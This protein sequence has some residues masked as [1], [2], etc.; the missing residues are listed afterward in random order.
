MFRAVLWLMVA[1]LGVGSVASAEPLSAT[2]L[3]GRPAFG[4]PSMSPDGSRLAMVADTGHGQNSLIVMQINGTD[5]KPLLKTAVPGL[6]AV[7]NY[8]W[9]SNDVL[10]MWIDIGGADGSV[11]AMLDISKNLLVAQE[12][13][14]AQLVRDRWGDA[15]HVLIRELCSI[16]QFCFFVWNI[17]TNRGVAYATAISNQKGVITHIINKDQLVADTVG[18][19]GK[20]QRQSW[21]TKTSS[22]VAGTVADTAPVKGA[23]QLEDVEQTDSNAAEFVNA[24]TRFQALR[25]HANATAVRTS[26]SHDIVGAA[27]PLP[28]PAFLSFMP[29]LDAAAE[30]AAAALPDRRVSWL[31]TSDDLKHALLSVQG[32]GQPREFWLWSAAD[33]RLAPFASS[34]PKLDLSRLGKQQIEEHW[35]D[36]DT[37]V[38]VIMPPT[39]TASTALLVSV[40]I[41]SAAE[42][43]SQ[44]A[45]FDQESQF[46]AQYGVVS[47]EVPVPRADSAGLHGAAWRQMVTQR[48]VRAT[49][50]AV[51]AG[52]GK[53]DKVCL[54]GGKMAGYAALAAAAAAPDKFSCLLVL[55]VA[56]KPAEL[57][58]PLII[59]GMAGGANFVFNMTGAVPQWNAMMGDEPGNS[60][61]P[62]DWSAALPSR[63]FV[64]YSMYAGSPG[65]A[66]ER[67]SG[68]FIAAVKRAGKSVQ[69]YDSSTHFEDVV[70]WVASLETAVVTFLH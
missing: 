19:D 10:L 5:V 69:L 14:Y 50:Q 46:L 23:L 34:Q 52:L 11:W 63:L 68:D 27:L 66:L 59:Q 1:C 47:V 36:D 51:K 7:T 33:N 60:G 35:F 4:A 2:L 55:D 26:G 22:W 15:D 18:A 65:A 16:D 39:G 67:Q 43:R 49:D 44:F 8:H 70:T 25:Q 30:Q 21:D 32:I 13:P 3:L 28:G 48:V 57:S 53:A 17:R 40:N 6:V 45:D 37:P 12:H 31:E 38:A 56:F 64:A 9:I 41:E 42:A 62:L 29:Q 58:H 20:I 54:S 24:R 61:N